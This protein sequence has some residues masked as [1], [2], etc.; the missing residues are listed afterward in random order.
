[1]QQIKRAFTLFELLI[2]ILLMGLVAFFVF[3]NP[4]IPKAR[5]E[6]VTLET[7][8]KFLRTNLQGN[9]ELV[10]INNCSSC[11]YLNGSSKPQSFS[12]PLQ[13]KVKNVYI[14]DRSDNP[15]KIEYGRLKDKKVCLRLRHYKNGSI[16]QEILELEGDKFLFIPAYFGNG[17]IFESLNDA[18]SWWLRNMQ[19]APKS[20]GDWY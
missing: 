19:N 12:L 7:L 8:P 15:E 17:K 16:S 1:M 2:V 5:A 14:L 11:F 4:T 10:C 18:Q 13:L 6:S 9:G 3:S 20:R